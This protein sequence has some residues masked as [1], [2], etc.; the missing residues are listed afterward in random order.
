[1]KETSKETL[2]V[3]LVLGG[4][5]VTLAS[6]LTAYTFRIGFGFLPLGVLS[7]IIGLGLSKLGGIRFTETAK[8]TL[9]RVLVLGGGLIIFATIFTIFTYERGGVAFVFGVLSTIL[10]LRLSKRWGIRFKD[11]SRVKDG[12]RDDLP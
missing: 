5:F 11:G 7:T 10:G 8:E 9:V 3:V 12:D 1:M 4:G 2:V 6:V